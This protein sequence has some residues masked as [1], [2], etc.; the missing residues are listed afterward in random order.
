MNI[1][2]L[3][4]TPSISA[5]VGED[6]I[7]K[8]AKT[9]G[10][11]GNQL[12]ARGLLDR[13]AYDD[14]SWDHRI[15]PRAVHER[16]DMIV[17]AAANFLFPK[18]DFGGMADYIERADLPVAIVGL[19]AQSSNYDP[20]INLMPG[21]ER[22]VKVI[23]ER[24]VSIGVRGPYT[25][26][27]LAHRGVHNVMVTGC[28]SYYMGGSGGISIKLRPFEE[29]KR[30]SINAS[31]DV[32]A[33]SFDK[34]KMR[35]LVQ[36][37]YSTGVAWK[38]DFIAQSE[39]SEIRL[40]DKQTKAVEESL[41]ELSTFLADMVPEADVRSWA[42]DHVR[43]F[44]DV[45]DWFNVIKTYDFVFGSRFHGC[46]IALQCG[47]PAIV[48]CHDT[49][50]EDMCRFLGMPYVNIVNLRRISV[51]ELYAM[52]DAAALNARYA[53]LYPIYCNFLRLNRLVV[54]E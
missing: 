5:E 29:I 33:H 15:D 27:V 43:A 17:V 14:I 12:I 28:P 16:F 2:L 38:A 22:F 19:G 35:R 40:A 41:K 54:K 37:I 51:D 24:A 42:S 1:F 23:A 50:T 32:I 20:N 45:D 26:E 39:Q 36:E 49:R 52:V 9:G 21:T 10:N 47:V 13:I 3:G 8:L 25:Q 30:I 53:E 11:T 18:F 46:M 31:R 34:E 48:V 44:F 6:P 4:A 7:S